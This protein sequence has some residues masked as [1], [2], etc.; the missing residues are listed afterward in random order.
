MHKEAVICLAATYFSEDLPSMLQYSSIPYAQVVHCI[1]EDAPAASVDVPS[2]H[3]VQSDRNCAARTP[4]YVPIGH[5]MHADALARSEYDPAG[6]A[7][8]VELL[9]APVCMEK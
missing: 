8:Q 5:S 3:V 2:G 1:S 9:M 4:L 6:H 7:W